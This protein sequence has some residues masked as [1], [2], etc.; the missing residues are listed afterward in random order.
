MPLPEGLLQVLEKALHAHIVKFNASAGGCINNGGEAV[1]TNGSFFVKWNN[2]K[3]F[4]DMFAAEAK[5]LNLIA[6]CGRLRVP[7]V[8]KVLQTEHVQLLVLEFIF[9]GSRTTQYWHL[10][11]E[12][13]AELHRHSSDGFGLDYHNYIGTLRQFN[14]YNSSWIDFFIQQRLEIQLRL[15]AQNGL[16]DT[17]LREQF[18]RMYK[19]LPDLLPAERPSLLHGDLWSGNLLADDNGK[20]CL[21]DPAVYYGHREAELAFTKL[22]GGFDTDFYTSYQE[23]FPL[24]PGFHH[25][26]DIYNLYP[27]LVHLNLFGR[28]YLSQITQTVQRFSR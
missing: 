7:R 8:I 15:A 23:A 28:G 17:R 13:L 9:S 12:Q 2:A 20:P 10:L 27:L 25:R 6:R 1:T 26:A 5:G 18:E 11:G 19:K 22:F 14:S 3:A 24:E 16:A 4:P 21:V